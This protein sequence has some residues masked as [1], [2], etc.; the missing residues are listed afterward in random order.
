MKLHLDFI[1]QVA[2]AKT[3]RRDLLFFQQ[4]ASCPH[5]YHTR[6]RLHT[7]S[8]LLNVKQGSSEYQYRSRWFNASR[9]RTRVYRFSSRRSIHSAIDQLNKLTLYLTEFGFSALEMNLFCQRYISPAVYC[10]LCIA[11]FKS[12]KF[13]FFETV[14][15]VMSSSRYGVKGNTINRRCAGFCQLILHP[16]PALM[17]A[18]R[19]IG[20]N[21][22][23]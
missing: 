9:N 10:I 13:L 19:L 21:F 17:N 7:V 23:A 6:W 8:L 1:H 22:L 2:L 20:L 11:I 16:D 3:Q 14:I 4:A 15:L 5:F 18:N 12:V